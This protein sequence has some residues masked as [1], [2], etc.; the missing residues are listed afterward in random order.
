MTW[1][2]YTFILI[3][4]ISVSISL[5]RGFVREAL[6]MIGWI[7]SFWV[8][9]SF[10]ALMAELLV[11]MIDIPSVRMILSFVVLFV[12][13]MMLS[14]AASNLLVD[15]VERAGLSGTD[16]TIGIFFGAGRGVVIAVILIT[17]MALTPMPQDD[18]WKES[19]F[20]PFFQGIA[21]WVRDWL[22]DGVAQKIVF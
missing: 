8:A 3:I 4:G 12:I 17:L 21:E 22:P 10:A 15:L 6:S 16:R 14:S 18:W 1:I 20:M 19:Y 13:T 2:D 5:M 7:L 9:S 11:D